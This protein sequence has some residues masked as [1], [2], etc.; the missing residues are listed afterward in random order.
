MPKFGL[1]FIPCVRAKNEYEFLKRQVLS[2][3]KDAEETY[4][5][6]YFL[7]SLYLETKKEIEDLDTEFLAKLFY[8]RVEEKHV[9]QIK[10]KLIDLLPRDVLK[11]NKDYNKDFGSD[12]D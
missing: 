9:V 8:Y 12:D 5:Q 11:R 3:Q 6:T 10:N 1:L 2:F 7:D 4:E